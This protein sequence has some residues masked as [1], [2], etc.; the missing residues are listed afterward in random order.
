MVKQI[1]KSH[2]I[3]IPVVTTLYGTDITLVEKD[4]SYEP[5]VS[6]SVSMSRMVSLQYHMISRKKRYSISISVTTSK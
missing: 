1:L 4:P 6:A 3:N 5:V 2:G